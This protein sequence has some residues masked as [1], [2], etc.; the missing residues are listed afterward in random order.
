MVG[1]DQWVFEMSIATRRMDA[2]DLR[3]IDWKIIDILR[4]GRNNAPNIAQRTGYSRQYIAERLG[5]LKRDNIL[6]PI[7]NGI[8]ELAPDEVP[9]KE[10]EDDEK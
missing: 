2:A 7:G 4:E 3:E 9:E 8:Y 1:T 6:V 5:T 10:Q